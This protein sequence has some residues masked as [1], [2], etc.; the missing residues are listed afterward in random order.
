MDEQKAPGEDKD[1]EAPGEQGAGSSILFYFF[2]GGGARPDGPLRVTF[3]AADAAAP[4]EE[5]GSAEGDP[6]KPP[7]GASA[8][9]GLESA[10]TGGAP[11]AGR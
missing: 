5:M 10:D 4:S 7:E 8:G 11:Q 2:L 6:L 9:P 3:P 1:A